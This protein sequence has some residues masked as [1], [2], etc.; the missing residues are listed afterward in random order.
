MITTGTIDRTTDRYNPMQ[1]A[2]NRAIMPV[3]D[4]PAG[5]EAGLSPGARTLQDFTGKTLAT[6][7][8]GYAL[9]QTRDIVTPFVSRFGIDAV[10]KCI[11]YGAGKYTH[12]ALETGRTMALEYNGERDVIRERLIIENSYNKS[13]SF[14]FMFGAFRS[15][16]ANGLYTGYAF[17]AI[18]R[19][20][21]GTIDAPGLVA[22]VL[23]QYDRAEKEGRDAFDL[24]RDFQKHPMTEDEQRQLAS[25]FKPF[26]PGTDEDPN[27]HARQLNRHIRYAA[28]NKIHARESLDNQRNAWGLLNGLNWSIARV[29]RGKSHLP[30]IISANLEAENLVKRATEATTTRE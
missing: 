15:V 21:S 13:R 5:P 2:I 20:H 26:D 4:I 7:S 17:A 24:W 22:G 28:D 12:V 11:Q 14:R 19:I 18:R 10:K 23:E 27:H 1:N 29:L 30:R 25:S 8:K 3:L 6:V 16:C 9:V